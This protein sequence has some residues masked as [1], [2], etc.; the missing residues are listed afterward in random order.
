MI[1]KSTFGNYEKY[2][3]TKGDMSVTVATLGATCIS[4]KFKG[5]EL[6]LGYDNPEGYLKGE[7]YIGAIVGRYANR[8]K[9][10]KFT[11]NGKE[12][13]LPANEGKNQLHGGPDAF[14]R[15]KFNAE[16]I[17]D[18]AVKLTYFSPDGENGY[19][20]NLT[21]AFTYT[22]TE[23]SF[24][25]DF[26]G[27]TDADTVYAPTTHLYFNFDGTGTI[28][29]HDMRILA[30]KYVAVDDES[31][32]TEIKPVDE[33]FDFT[34]TRKIKSFV[35]H[36]FAL[37]KSEGDLVCEASHNGVKMTLRSDYPGVQFYTG[38]FLSGKY[39]AFEGFA[40]EPGLFPNSPNRDDFPNAT[41]KA[42]EHFHRYAK[43]SFESI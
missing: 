5:K 42:G 12:Y 3:I 20:G 37:N 18:N 35:D 10:A 4:V 15:K 19:P 28:L 43:F 41:L 1:T 17:G 36:S 8:I 25:I 11:L 23:N 38:K 33:Y 21:A 30:D 24:N 22:V 32:A 14:D 34:K 16:E 7:G 13:V 6:A 2:E 26:E 40:V 9:D 27:D 29:D 39:K 31:I